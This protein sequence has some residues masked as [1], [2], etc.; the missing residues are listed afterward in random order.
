MIKVYKRDGRTKNFDKRF[1]EIAVD[2]AKDEIGLDD[3]IG[4]RVADLVEDYLID[5]NIQEIQIEEIQDLVIEM[6]NQENK[7]VAEAYKSYREKRNLERKHPIDKQILELMEGT[8]EF[9]A[10]ENANKNSTLISTQRDL[11]AGTIS[12]SLATRY[13][14]PKY[15]M[16]AHNEGLIKFHDLDYFI[17]PMTN[18]IE[19][20]G[21]ITYKDENGVKNIQ[22]K[23]LKT[24]FNMKNEDNI[25]V[26]KKC[27]VLGR[28]GWTRLRGISVRKSDS[29]ETKYEFQTRGINLKTTGLHRIPVIRNGKEI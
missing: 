5:N 12:R 15:L 21:W 17:N 25:Q 2:K 22:L 1:I 28:N 10:K 13:K 26:N 3:E 14:I 29:N 20:N 9:L 18:C 8:N 27:F 7:E 6:L 16:D 23:Q 11:M 4:T 24:M 19:E